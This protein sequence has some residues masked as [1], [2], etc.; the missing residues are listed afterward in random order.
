MV[1]P[2]SFQFVTE[3][4]PPDNFMEL[5]YKTQFCEQKIINNPADYFILHLCFSY[6]ILS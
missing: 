1:W 5:V 4:F 6:L 2:N 3:L